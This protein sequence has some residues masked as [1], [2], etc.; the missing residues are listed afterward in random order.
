MCMPRRIFYVTYRR[1]QDDLRCY[2]NVLTHNTLYNKVM[3]IYF[4]IVL[5][6][7]IGM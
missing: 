2:K 5:N 3:H 6:R 1:D 7:S 4:P